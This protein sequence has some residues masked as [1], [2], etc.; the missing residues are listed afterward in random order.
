M[1]KKERNPVTVERERSSCGWCFSTTKIKL[2]TKISDLF[3][4][5]TPI[6]MAL[7]FYGGYI[8]CKSIHLY[9]E[10]R[11]K[12][13]K[14]EI[15]KISSQIMNISLNLLLYHRSS[16]NEKKALAEG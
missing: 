16:N 14:S 13:R 4:I 15:N 1:I 8:E 9:Q 2:V 5:C 6:A 3:C 10:K 11:D 12:K 7:S